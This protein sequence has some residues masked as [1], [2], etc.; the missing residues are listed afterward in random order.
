MSVC[1]VCK[2][3]FTGGVPCSCCN[4]LF[5]ANYASNK[6]YVKHYD[7]EPD[8]DVDGNSMNCTEVNS[9]EERVIIQ[10][11][12]HMLIYRCRKCN[13]NGGIS[14]A[15]DN[16]IT[17]LNKKLSEVDEAIGII[18]KIDVGKI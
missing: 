10:Q 9:L 14:P 18:K 4:S 16:M 11:K 8:P 12:E 15:L 17:L 2:I 5:H 3:A 6:E 1:A 7:E 13:E